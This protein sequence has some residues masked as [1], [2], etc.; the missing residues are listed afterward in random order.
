MPRHTEP[1]DQRIKRR[2]QV[3]DNGCWNWTGAKSAQGYGRITLATGKTWGRTVWAHRASYEVFVG[4]IPES[5]TIDHLCRNRACVNPEHLEPVTRT[6]NLLRGH[7]AR[8]A[9]ASN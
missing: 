9:A 6:E 4:P 2:T 8:R 1:L 3:D 7:K 5:L